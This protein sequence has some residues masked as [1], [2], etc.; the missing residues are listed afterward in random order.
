LLF[1]KLFI[2]LLKLLL[3]LLSLFKI[4]LLSLRTSFSLGLIFLN[5]GD[6]FEFALNGRFKLTLKEL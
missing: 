1:E 3:L 6:I 2:L 5:L 4:I